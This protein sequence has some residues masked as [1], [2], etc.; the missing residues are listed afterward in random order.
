M[1]PSRI[2]T[3]RKSATPGIAP[4]EPFIS[5]TTSDCTKASCA[6]CAGLVRQA[7]RI[8]RAICVNVSTGSLWLN[9][10]S[11]RLHSVRKRTARSSRNTESVHTT[12]P[13]CVIAP[14]GAAR[15]TPDL[16][17]R[18][19]LARSA[20]ASS[21][22]DDSHSAGRGF[23]RNAWKS[24]YSFSSALRG[25]SGASRVSGNLLEPHHGFGGCKGRNGR[26]QIRS[27]S[28]WGANRESGGRRTS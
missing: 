5:T 14:P 16:H 19:P 13:K 9:K 2:H 25:V 22:S 23:V 24:T 15:Q 1:D 12:D 11:R 7:S 27:G 28:A 6:N 18:Y 20:C 26:N 3:A 21:H 4:L 17:G 8:E 10:S